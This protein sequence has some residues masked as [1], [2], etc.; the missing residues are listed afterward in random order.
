M[1]RDPIGS[2]PWQGWDPAKLYDLKPRKKTDMQKA[3][4]KAKQLFEDEN[5]QTRLR[6]NRET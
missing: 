2:K 5:E 6:P 4:E 3:F 1:N